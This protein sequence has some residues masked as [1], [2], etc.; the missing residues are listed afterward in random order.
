M[1]TN[2][3]LKLPYV[4]NVL[5]LIPV[6]IPTL[7]D[8]Y[9]TD[10]DKFPDS[11]GWSSLVGSLW[12]GILILSLVGLFYPFHM[13]PVLIL[14][15]IYKSVWLLVYVLPRIVKQQYHSIP[16]GIAVSFSCIVVA[17]PCIIPWSNFFTKPLSHDIHTM[18]QS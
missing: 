1:T 6:A 5:V 11:Q 10:Q 2:A 12:T 4:L 16:L 14:Q 3:I 15:I 13:I 17:W 9:A 18:K 8:L 7:F